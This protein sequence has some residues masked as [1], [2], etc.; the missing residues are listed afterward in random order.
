MGGFPQRNVLLKSTSGNQEMDTG[1][2]LVWKRMTYNKQ[3]DEKYI[4]WRLNLVYASF[5]GMIG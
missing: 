5:G 2:S 3:I 1:N 4:L